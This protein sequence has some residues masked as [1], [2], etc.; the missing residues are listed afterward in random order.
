MDL[1]IVES[2]TKAKTFSKFLD[3]KKFRVEATMG[4]I[5][6]LPESKLGID[7]AH[8]FKPDYVIS[9]KKKDVVD[10]ITKLAKK[11]KNIILATDADREGEAISYHIAYILGFID[12]K[13]PEIS[14]K[15]N[16]T[17]K[18]IVFHEITNEALAHALQH[19]QELN[20]SLIDSQQAR[21]ILDRLVGYQVSPILWKK[22]GKRWLS[23][24]RVQTTA[25]RFVVERE[26]EINKFTSEPFYKV[27]GVFEDSSQKKSIEARL[28]SKD[29]ILYEK[30]T[31]IKL[32]DGSYTYAKTS[33]DKEGAL[34]I[35]KDLK[36]DSFI[37]SEVVENEVK[38]SPNPPF[39]T[40]TLQQ[41]ASG[42][43][44]Y[45][46]KLTMRLAQKLYEK[47]LITYHR[48]DS[49][50]LSEKFIAESMTWIKKEY[51]NEYLPKTARLYKTKSKNAQEAH[52]AIRPT[53]LLPTFEEDV[54]LGN[55]HRKLYELIFRRA[56]GS[57]MAD[58]SIKTTKVKI[59]SGKKYLF[60]SSYERILFPGF[61]TLNPPKKE[62]NIVQ[63]VPEKGKKLDSTKLD[64][65]ETQTNP[66]P[67]YN[68]AS[69][70]KTL[71]A[72]GIGRPSTYA[73]TISTIQ[74]RLYMEK[75]EHRFYPT[76]LGTAVC[77]YL[78]KAFA[79]IFEI[80]FTADLEDK[81]DE[82]AGGRETMLQV[83][84]EFDVPFKKSLKEA[85]EDKTF[86]DVQE[87]TDEKCPTCGKPLLIR[88]SK[89]GKFYACSGYPDCK[90]T[91][92]FYETVKE[93]C[94]KCNGAIVI[95]YTK[96][97]KKF[98]GCSNYPKCDFAAWKLH[99][100]KKVETPVSA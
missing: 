17:I 74:E 24:G 90:F 29:G 57:Q 71:E 37:I 81:L 3:P 36:S 10:T 40:S 12:E 5:R 23:A 89:Y 44:G 42:R 98:Y 49:F 26:K 58:A 41:E 95:R 48:T 20:I 45:S 8:K 80:D 32:F 67:R 19:P 39:I 94:P 76:I 33:I 64:F 92:P 47:G 31:T 16:A 4:H 68:E 100:I 73:P 86:I 97:K 72:R 52:E 18:R 43:H 55:G 22:I 85:G 38:R 69:L 56:V 66:P 60:E 61:L 50:N 88:F 59:L 28:I 79:T 99:E 1:I 87:K 13:W 51:G 93:L 65:I 63:F 21:R 62:D 30:K 54:D 78:T 11:A 70:I 35:E 2:P 15:K 6:D 34:N 7:I 25:L 77:D 53:K 14:I 82:I 75:K 46:S 96:K 27:E 9:T 84:Q 83:L 91:R